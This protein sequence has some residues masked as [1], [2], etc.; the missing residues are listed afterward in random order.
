MSDD[1]YSPV[2]L[3]VVIVSFNTRTITLKCLSHLH[4]E[5]AARDAEV[6][7][8]DN[9]STD[10]S[11]EAI[12]LE[13]P[14]VKL[15]V[16]ELNLGFGAANNVAM[17]QARG[18]SILLLN[19]DAFVHV[20]AVGRLIRELDADRDVGVVGPKLLNADGST[21][22][23]CF[24]YPTPMRA[25]LENL[26]V[27]KLFKPGSRLGDYR[28]WNHDQVRS[29]DWL[30]GACLL[31]RREVVQQVGG[32]DERFFMYSEETD[33]QKRIRDAGW[34]I[35]FTPEARAT[36][37]GGASGEAARARINGYF[38]DSLDRYERKHHGL[39]GLVAL[40]LAMVVGGLIRLPAWIAAYAL[41]P[42]RRP[43]AA[44]KLRLHRWLIMRQ[45]FHWPGNVR[46]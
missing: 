13:F 21:Q 7:V 42:S 10:G 18:R 1:A 31:V 19:S 35:R 33:W 36:H 2:E 5:L 41:R 23:S 46:V 43:E 4:R 38:F 39:L 28:R 25:W 27:A 37:L 9:A 44:A 32:F 6:I 29:V 40:R 22:R 3:S 24:R 30:I 16:S 8:V 12:R 17:R 34:Q 45:L 11:V 15:V 26:G 14:S 20:G